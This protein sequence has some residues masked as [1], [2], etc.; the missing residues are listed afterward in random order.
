MFKIFR[1]LMEVAI[2]FKLV[3]ANPTRRIENAAPKGRKAIW[4]DAE[5]A[6]LRDAA[7]EMG[8]RG[9][10]VA[11][12]IAFDTQMA[13]VD[14]P[15][16]TLAM[17]VSDARGVLTARGKTAR[18]VIATL[19]QTRRPCCTAT[20]QTYRLHSRLPPRSFAIGRATSTAKT[21]WATTSATCARSPFPGTGGS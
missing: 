1:A 2:G 9:L 21:L 13:P 4:L 17:R 5:V 15:S 19:S 16:L 12:A 7:W 18:D 6:R 11:I 8:Y 20:L 14:V 3:N 10:S